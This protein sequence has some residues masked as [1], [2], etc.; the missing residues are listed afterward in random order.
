[1][2]WFYQFCNLL[3]TN[4]SRFAY[5]KDKGIVGGVYFN[6][7]IKGPFFTDKTGN[8]RKLKRLPENELL[9]AEELKKEWAEKEKSKK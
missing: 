2:Y 8:W 6:H 5:I 4:I 7:F 3:H 9:W 1:V